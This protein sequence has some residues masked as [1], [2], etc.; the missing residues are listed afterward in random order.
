[1]VTQ[2]LSFLY[3]IYRK[4]LYYVVKYVSNSIEL[5]HQAIT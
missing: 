2:F 5:L 1:M 3:R 4:Y